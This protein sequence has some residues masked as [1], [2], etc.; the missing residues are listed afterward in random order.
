MLVDGQAAGV[1]DHIA[2]LDEPSFLQDQMLVMNDIV[3]AFFF[4]IMKGP[5]TPAKA[6][7]VDQALFL[8]KNIKR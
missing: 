2:G 7:L 3:Y 4:G 5:Y 8:G 6:E 1:Y